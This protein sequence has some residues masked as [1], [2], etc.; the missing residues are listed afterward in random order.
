MEKKPNLKRKVRYYNKRFGLFGCLFLNEVMQVTIEDYHAALKKLKPTKKRKGKSPLRRFGRFLKIENLVV[1]Y[2]QSGD[3]KFLI[4]AQRL[5]INITK[6]YQVKIIFKGVIKI[7][8][9]A[10]TLSYALVV[11]LFSLARQSKSFEEYETGVD[12]K[13]KYTTN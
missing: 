8:S 7:Y 5:R 2:H 1:Q 4:E 10:P 12:E 6:P 13:L 9:Y 3:L 11:E